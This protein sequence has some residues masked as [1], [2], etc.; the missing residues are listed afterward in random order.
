MPSLKS[1]VYRVNEEDG[2][3]FDGMIKNN[4]ASY[5]GAVKDS[6]Q[7]GRGLFASR[8]EHCNVD[9]TDTHNSVLFAFPVSGEE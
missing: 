6:L 8:Q 4:Q 2:L 9:H 7:M 1:K 3:L 5:G